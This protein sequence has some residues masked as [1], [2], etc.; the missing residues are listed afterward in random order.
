MNYRLFY[1]G[2]NLKKKYKELSG[3]QQQRLTLIMVLYADAPITFF[4]EV[5]TGLDFET[6]QLMDKIRQWYKNKRCYCFIGYT[7][8]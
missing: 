4:D 3:G 1:F 2:K 5:T 8:L 7:L 6:R